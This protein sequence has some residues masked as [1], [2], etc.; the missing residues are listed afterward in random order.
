MFGNAVPRTTANFEALCT[1]A[2]GYG[3]RGSTFHRVI[4]D[5]MLQGGDITRGDGTGGRSIYGDA[6]DDENFDLSH[7]VAGKLSMANAGPNTQSSQFFVTT[8]PCPWLDGKHVVFGQVLEGL[9]HIMTLQRVPTTDDKPDVD[10]VITDC[11][12]LGPSN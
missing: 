6:F 3:Y 7:D 12:I 10:V 5:F 2:Q 9:D 4:P 1:H 8:V 11:S